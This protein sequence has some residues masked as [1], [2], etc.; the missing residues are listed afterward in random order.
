MSVAYSQDAAHNYVPQ[1]NCFAPLVPLCLTKTTL[2]P[3]AGVTRLCL[4]SHNE[5]VIKHSLSFVN[6]DNILLPVNSFTS[7]VKI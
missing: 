1:R 2:M 7:G 3:R 5:K 6:S 4:L